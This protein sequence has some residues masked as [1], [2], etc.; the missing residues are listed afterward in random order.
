MS[1]SDRT[2]RVRV[3][4]QWGY[5]TRCTLWLVGAGGT[6]AIMYGDHGDFVELVR[7]E[8]DVRGWHLVPVAFC[9]CLFIH[10]VDSSRHRHRS[11]R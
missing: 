8:G 4:I 10:I 2:A 9:M 6:S 11:V 5:G 1:S 7:A 3:V